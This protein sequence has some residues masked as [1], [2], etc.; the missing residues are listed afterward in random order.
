[1]SASLVGSEMCIR[2]SLQTGPFGA[3]LGLSVRKDACR[4]KKYVSPERPRFAPKD[5]KR[6]PLGSVGEVAWCTCL[7]RNLRAEACAPSR[8]NLL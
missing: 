1:M 2:D 7:R 5:P 6:V 3:K 4:C 8:A